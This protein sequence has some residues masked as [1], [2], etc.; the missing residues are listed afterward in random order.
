MYGPKVLGT[1][2]VA[3]GI[4]LLP[5]TGDSRVLFVLA[6]TLVVSGVVILVASTIL[7]RKARRSE[8]N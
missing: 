7:S 5:S 6:S 1:T 8:A 2:N 3:T 4:S